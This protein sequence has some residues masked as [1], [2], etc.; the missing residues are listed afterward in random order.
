MKKILALSLVLLVLA[1]CSSE[2]YKTGLGMF[3]SVGSSKAA[4]AEA[5]GTA[6]AD[7]TA[8]AV[9]VDSQGKI[10]SISVDV[11]QAKVNFAADGTLTTDL[12]TEFQTK[13]EL[14]EDY[15]MTKASP[16]G[17]E[18]YQQMEAFEEWAT[19]KTVAEVTGMATKVKDESHPAVP[20]VP[21]LASSC[22]MNVSDFLAAIE[23]AGAN[24]K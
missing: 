5:D 24:V 23:K 4:T 7:V 10:V 2:T 15:G 20:D 9:T 3:T 21:E 6:Q 12:A 1:G 8:A 14:K 11:V 13:K 18:W 16:I 19:G 17:K 22:T